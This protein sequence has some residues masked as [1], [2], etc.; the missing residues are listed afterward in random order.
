V[1]HR[2]VAAIIAVSA[3]AASLA[4]T[5]CGGIP[6]SGAVTARD[7]INDDAKLNVGFSPPIPNKNASQEDI[8]LGF[9][10]AAVSADDD[11]GIAR[12]F[13][14]DDFR[15]SWQPNTIALIRS[16]ASVTSRDSD[17]SLDYQISSS[18][19]VD[20]NGRYVEEQP[21]SQTLTF[22]FKQNAQHQ[23]RIDS[24]PNGIVLSQESF[25]TTFEEHALYF[26]DPTNNYLVP[27]VRWFPRTALVS[28]RV[29]SA[30]LGGQANW[31]QQGV[32]HT[33]FP[34]GTALASRVS[35]DSGTATVDLTD[36]VLAASPSQKERMRQQ[37]VAS[38]GYATVVVSVNGVPL[39]ISDSGV[40]KA[41]TVA[42]VS[43]SLLVRRDSS[44][45]FLASDNSITAL[46]K[47]SD[48]IIKLDP[49]AVTLARTR[50]ASAVLAAQGVFLVRPSDSVAKLL[51][52][53]PG[54]VAPSADPLGFIWSVPSNDAS[55][56]RA[57]EYGGAE[58]DIAS[59]LPAGATVVS[60][61][62]SRDGTRVYFQLST[63]VG[64]R[65]LV[66]GIIRQDGVPISLGEPVEL[67]AIQS[68][69][70]GATWVDDSTIA[71]LSRDGDFT[72]VT[73]FEIGGGRVS[74]GRTAGGVSIVGGNGEDGLRVTTNE[75][76]VLRPRGTGW[77]DTGTKVSFVATQG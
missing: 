43:P 29:V 54:L 44:F 49:R 77:Q 47:Q 59:P 25:D 16:G 50:A 67:R 20:S 68:T 39:D 18:A 11:Y 72:A 45:G 8:M 30:L 40:T 61:G 32:V 56:L 31:L 70:I 38:L 35:V 51:D 55:A 34:T 58:H 15:A 23:W 36:E 74:L 76:E 75:G 46:P 17:A 60:F 57:Y 14:S 71:T 28:T 6:T 41:T 5:G 66:L 42:S 26:F 53:R 24:A 9:I 65:L 52:A 64:S 1:I 48:K 2:G 4:L 19:Y 3:I 62:V 7:L 33:E 69:P 37:L 13:L 27:D 12:Q 73:V 63:D 21:A 10:Q 22:V